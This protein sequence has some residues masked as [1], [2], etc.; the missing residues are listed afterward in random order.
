[1][2]CI[3]TTCKSEYLY[4]VLHKCLTIVQCVS[5]ACC[6]HQSITLLCS[7][8]YCIVVFTS[9]LYSCVHQ[10]IALLCSPVHCIVVLTSLMHGCV[11]LSF[12]LLCSPGGLYT[13]DVTDP[14]NPIL[15]SNGINCY[16]GD[17]YVHDAQCVVYNGPDA[18]YVNHDVCFCYNENTFT[19]VDME[20]PNNI[21][22]LS[23]TGYAG[24]SY[25]HQVFYL[26]Y[27][28][29]MVKHISFSY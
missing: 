4:N 14:A 6:V 27:L 12:A 18:D 11:H 19:I 16:D 21:A 17:G 1:M 15:P 26:F 28:Y 2:V 9:P 23:R 7:L 5:V 29:T 10:Y 13:V 22:L 25:T 8:I 3:N 20:D 24:A